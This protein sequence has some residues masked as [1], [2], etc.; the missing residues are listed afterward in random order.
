MAVAILACC[1]GGLAACDNPSDGNISVVATIFPEYDWAREILNG[2]E[3]DVSLTLL[4]DNGSDLHSYQPSVRDIATI[5]ACDLFIYV[6]GESDKWVDEALSQAKNPDM[7]VIRLLDVL[8][9]AVKEEEAVEGMEAEKGTGEEAEYDEHVWLSVKNAKLFCSAI[10]EKLSALDKD[11]SADYA[12]NALSYNGK[13]SALDESYSAAVQSGN[14]DTLLVA[15]RFPFRYLVD[16]YGLSYFAAFP[17]CSA[18]TEASFKTVIFLA[19]KVDEL[20]LPCI[21]T[22][23]GTSHAL[24]ETVRANTTTKNQAILSLNSMQSVNAASIAD[25]TTY[26]AVMT[27]NLTVLK[28]ALRAA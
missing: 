22:I 10:A 12:Q 25:G 3:N 4:V 27:D 23:E 5:S 28:Q 26:L 16:D 15:D 20:N 9:S 19:G 17:G 13:L 11:H 6:G 2:H 7:T 14:L 24:A 18:E 1:C 8:G 21:L